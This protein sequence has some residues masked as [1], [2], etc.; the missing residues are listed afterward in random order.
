MWKYLNICYRVNTLAYLCVN[1]LKSWGEKEKSMSI[2]I[3][4]KSLKQRFS[5]LAPQ[6]WLMENRPWPQRI[7]GKCE[8]Q[9]SICDKCF[10]KSW[11]FVPKSLMCLCSTV[12]CPCRLIHSTFKFFAVSTRKAK[13]AS[14]TGSDS[15]YVSCPSSAKIAKF[16]FWERKSTAVSL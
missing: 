8:V 10:W 5:S 4:A 14:R 9:G 13:S 11:S 15:S 1:I 7:I 16:P 3:P 2:S 12:S 6:Y